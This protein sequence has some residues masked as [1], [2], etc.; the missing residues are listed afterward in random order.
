M[1]R[2]TARA[3]RHHKRWKRRSNKIIKKI[4]Q[5][6]P[7]SA[8]VWKAMLDHETELLNK[9]IQNI[10]DGKYRDM[11]DLASLLRRLAADMTDYMANGV[12]HDHLPA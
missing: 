2:G 12:L 1:R 7:G 4:C 6:V 11:T 9:T 10:Q 5:V 3:R 8:E